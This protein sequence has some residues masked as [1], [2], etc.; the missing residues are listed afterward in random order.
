MRRVL[1]LLVLVGAVGCGGSDATPSS[2]GPDLDEGARIF[3]R[4]CAVC[5]GAGGQGA[6]APALTAVTETFGACGDQVDWVT[7][8]SER[9]QD[10]V[11]QTYG[12]TGT[13]ITAAMPSFEGTL[14]PTEIAQVV[15]YERH[16]FG[17]SDAVAA[18]TDCG[19]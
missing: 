15:A 11:G 13:E 8:G 17:G 16:R 1:A 10:E 9:W 3:A 7:L 18:L 12:D 6:A 2:L 5:H 19:L 14:T 4:S